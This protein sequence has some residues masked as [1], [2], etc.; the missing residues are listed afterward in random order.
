MIPLLDAAE[1]AA[2]AAVHAELGPAPGDPCQ[3]LFNDTWSTDTAYKAEI[4]ARLHAIF[5][6]PASRVFS[7]H[8]TL[9]WTTITKW[10]GPQGTVVSHRDPTFVDERSFRSI[11]VWC[12]ITDLAIGDGTLE[13]VPGSHRDAPV[14]RPHQAVEN[15]VPE[16]DEAHPR[17]TVPVP[18]AA[19]WALVYDHALVHRSGPTDAPQPRCVVAGLLVPDAAQAGYTLAVNDQVAHTV[20]LD[21]SFLL[22]RKL[23][24]LPIQAALEECEILTSWERGA[25]RSWQRIRP[26]RPA[27]SGAAASP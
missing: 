3:G 9:G 20:A 22:Q 26:G 17:P 14:V 2:V 19:G 4:S 21:E 16:V 1:A 18:L 10:P 24:Q 25:G 15:L 6:G 8:R 5:D 23:D 13:V 27:G 11:G 7:N 12:A